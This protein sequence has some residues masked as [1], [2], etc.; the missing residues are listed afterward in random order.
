MIK[1]NK[2]KLQGKIKT[3]VCVVEGYRPGPG[4]APKQRTIK[5]FG[6]QEEQT[7]PEAFM[8]KVREFNAHF[9]DGV[10]RRYPSALPHLFHRPSR[11][12]NYPA[13]HGGHG[14]HR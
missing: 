9:K 11:S 12:E 13:P 3:W 5:S 2:V 1:Y 4:L 6:Y 10:E 8:E 14:S 7:D